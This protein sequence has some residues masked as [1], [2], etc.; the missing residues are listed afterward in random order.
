MK[1]NKNK[2]KLFL[3]LCIFLTLELTVSEIIPRNLKEDDEDTNPIEK[4]LNDLVKFFKAKLKPLK[5]KI[6]EQTA[7]KVI[8][9]MPKKKSTVTIEVTGSEINVSL[10]NEYESQELKLENIEFEDEKELIE[11]NYVDKFI[12]HLQQVKSDLNE[13]LKGVEAGLTESRFTGFFGETSFTDIKSSKSKSDDSLVFE[14]TYLNP[15]LLMDNDK[16][17]GEINH[18]GNSHTLRI[19]TK[20]FQKTFELAV[21]TDGYLNSESKK[22]GDKV[23]AHLDSMYYL[24]ENPE[25][26]SAERNF[27]FGDY[28][29]HLEELLKENLGEEF[30]IEVSDEEVTISN[31]EG[32]VF[33]AKVEENEL[34]NSYFTVI[35]ANI[36][37]A[38]NQE[39]HI[40]IPDNSIYTLDAMVDKFFLELIDYTKHA[41]NKFNPD[42]AVTVFA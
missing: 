33:T 3:I 26:D 32:P 21:I 1:S 39:Y 14:M 18:N 4:L 17:M 19:V 15:K 20:F 29:E 2:T 13:I 16:I 37:I 9:D 27:M 41:S 28:I 25:G 7:E 34:N 10:V 24:N 36:L 23:L 22:L 11:T 5:A 42:E 31:D 8:F 6:T 30:Q 40:V 38:G 35:T 12:G